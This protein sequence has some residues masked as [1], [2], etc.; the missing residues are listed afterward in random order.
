MSTNGDHLNK[1]KGIVDAIVFS[2]DVADSPYLYRGYGTTKNFFKARK[3]IY[4]SNPVSNYI[5]AI[6]DFKIPITHDKTGPLQ[7]IFDLPGHALPHADPVPVD[8]YSRWVNAIGLWAWEKIEVLYATTEL[9]TLTPWDM[10]DK[11]TR[12]RDTNQLAAHDRL[13][14][15]ASPATRD[16][17]ARSD[18]TI[19]CDLNLPHTRGSS[20]Y[21]EAMQLS[22]EIQIRVH[23]RPLR[24]VIETDFGADPPGVA[25]TNVKL[26]ALQVY[27][28]GDERNHHT[29]STEALHGLV[30]LFED[31][32]YQEEKVLQNSTGEVNIN[33]RNFKTSAKRF[34]F[35][36][37]K[38][39]EITTPYGND[40][41][42]FDAEPVE[43]GNNPQVVRRWK[44]G[45]AGGDITD[46]MENEYTRY[47]LKSEYHDG[48]PGTV[49]FAW[50]FA[51]DV[52]DLL[53]ATGSYNLGNT[54]N[55]KL[56]IDLGS[57]VLSEDYT[58]I[59]FANEHNT[60]QHVRGDLSNNFR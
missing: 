45:D 57:N 14:G 43:G 11:H 30:R 2:S 59:A 17:Q 29:A 13:L 44:I 36:I 56:Y 52:D 40:P 4:P 47:F 8:A 28:E 15:F 35:M 48:P 55:L 10:F 19:I 7:L 33:L 25:I 23:W 49:V 5:G 58:V 41:F 37:M 12:L 32:T 26:R 9:Y 54:T 46:W 6:T 20:R 31:F 51:N 42:G 60:T 21:I 22:Q 39:S 53:N 18:Q 3:D 1:Q 34:G 27:L 50:S 24:S 16:L 38:T